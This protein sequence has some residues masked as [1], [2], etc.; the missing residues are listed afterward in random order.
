MYAID[1]IRAYWLHLAMQ[2]PGGASSERSGEYW[3]RIHHH[4]VAERLSR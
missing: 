1:H 4:D 2:I 3:R